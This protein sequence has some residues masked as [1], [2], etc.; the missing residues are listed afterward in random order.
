MRQKNSKPIGNPQAGEDVCAG[1]ALGF[2]LRTELGFSPIENLTLDVFRAVCEVYTSGSAQPWE[3]AFKI[4][5]ENLGVIDGPLV[6]A[7]TTA[8]LRALRSERKIGFSYLSIGCQHV[9]PDELAVAGLLKA[10]R[11]GDERGIQRGLM[12]ALDRSK[13]SAR[14]QAAARALAALQL[15]IGPPASDAPAGNDDF[16]TQTVQAVYLH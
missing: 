14:T 8:L 16:Q 6:V 11:T 7:R 12:L 2:P 15:Q 4:A 5:E 9:S 1:H 3:I 13:T 10:A